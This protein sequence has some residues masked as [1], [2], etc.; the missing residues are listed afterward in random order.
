MSSSG[1]PLKLYISL[2]SPFNL[3]LQPNKNTYH[4]TPFY[5][6][7]DSHCSYLCVLRNYTPFKTQPISSGILGPILPEDRYLFKISIELHL[8]LSYGTHYFPLNNYFVHLYS[9]NRL[10]FFKS[11]SRTKY[12][13]VAKILC[14]IFKCQM[15]GTNDYYSGLVEKMLLWAGMIL[16]S[17]LEVLEAKL[18]ST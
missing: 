12:L 13:Y 6:C 5:L 14:A 1:L 16:K 17:F 15:N 11:E 2:F 18:S 7:L 3:F 10:H 4:L 9:S 8:Y